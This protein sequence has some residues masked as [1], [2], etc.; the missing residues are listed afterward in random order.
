MTEPLLVLLGS[1]ASGKEAAA[2]AAATTLGAEIVCADSVKP[3]RGLAIAAAAPGPEA[4]ARVRHHLVGVVDP[5][6]TLHAQR[7]CEL[8]DAAVADIRA[9][10]ARALLVGGSALYLRALLFGLFAGPGADPVLRAELRA[11]EAANPGW[12]HGW[13]SAHDPVGAARLHPNDTKRLVRAVEVLRTTGRPIH[14]L[15]TQ[16]KGPPRVPH[17]AIG[18]RRTR[19]DLWRRI[20][21]RIDR[22]LAD[23]L[24]EEIRA[25]AA[26]GRIAPT[27]GEVIGVKELLP[28]LRREAET[29]V[30]DDA[31]I[32]AAV[33][34]LRRNTRVL[35]RRQDT[36]WRNFA[37]VDWLDVAADE[38][39]AETGAR[40]AEHFGSRIASHPA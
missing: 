32:A 5:G 30:R 19:A 17:I 11:Q 35:A 27:A 38:P 16:W 18:L 26:R 28:A 22:M 6:E 4:L 7:W 2:L 9:R 37:G 12:L 21:A 36:W 40:V 1:T 25:L 13:L 8:V 3:Y 14:E 15:Q 31:A 20:D 34:L 10:G 33:I 39:A 29:G 23:G 24:V